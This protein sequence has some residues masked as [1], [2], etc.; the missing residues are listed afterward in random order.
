MGAGSPIS[1]PWLQQTFSIEGALHRAPLAVAGALCFWRHLF[2][3]PHITY[4][5]PE[6]PVEGGLILPSGQ[7]A[8]P[9][10]VG[11]QNVSVDEAT[12]DLTCFNTSFRVT[13][14][15][16]APWCNLGVGEQ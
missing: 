13:D 9:W 10:I 3:R 2:L 15:D 12:W 5:E 1:A 8:F 16:T 6:I 7:Q 14:Y 11:L 4:E